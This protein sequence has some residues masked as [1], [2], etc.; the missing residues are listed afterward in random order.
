M[1]RL[2]EWCAKLQASASIEN[3]P[4]ETSCLSLMS[5]D[6]WQQIWLIGMLAFNMQNGRF[7][8]R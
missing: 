2:L 6:Q 7:E 8:R 5:V 3:V 1:N 4:S